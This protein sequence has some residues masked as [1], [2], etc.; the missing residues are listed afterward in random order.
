MS[1]ESVATAVPNDDLI[2][3]RREPVAELEGTIV[4]LRKGCPTAPCHS[5]GLEHRRRLSRSLTPPRIDR[6]VLSGRA[7]GYYD[8]NERV[9]YRPLWYL[10]FQSAVR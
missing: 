4:A 8:P 6:E 7:R 5:L 10:L 1:V 2:W 3:S 9:R